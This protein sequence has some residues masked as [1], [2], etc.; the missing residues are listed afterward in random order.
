MLDIVSCSAP[1]RPGAKLPRNIAA[2]LLVLGCGLWPTPAVAWTES[3]RQGSVGEVQ[4][5]NPEA[6][7]NYQAQ[8]GRGH[9]FVKVWSPQVTGARD[10]AGEHVAFLQAVATDEDGNKVKSENYGPYTVRSDQWFQ[11]PDLTFGFPSDDRTRRLGL[12]VVWLARD[13]AGQ[14][15]AVGGRGLT[16]DRVAH[17]PYGGDHTFTTC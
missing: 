5:H 10:I 9:V 2:I 4:L 1:D 13:E 8:M 14:W 17:L 3:A 11:A 12:L 15:K 16:L 7:C 6:S